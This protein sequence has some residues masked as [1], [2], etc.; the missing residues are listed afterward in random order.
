ME[1]AGV[2]YHDFCRLIDDANERYSSLKANGKEL[3]KRARTN[4]CRVGKEKKVADASP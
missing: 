1:G 3:R 2:V 4:H